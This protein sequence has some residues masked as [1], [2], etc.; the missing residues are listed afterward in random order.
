M[1]L[2]PRAIRNTPVPPTMLRSQV[3]SKSRIGP[4][5]DTVLPRNLPAVNKKLTADCMPGGLTRPASANRAWNRPQSDERRGSG[6]SRSSLSTTPN[7]PKLSP[8]S[9]DCTVISRVA[10][11]PVSLSCMYT[12]VCSQTLSPGRPR[13]TADHDEASRRTRS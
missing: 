5:T 8:P 7:C 11:G 1:K 4:S 13:A 10:F 12:T 9:G 6:P 3:L 2:Y